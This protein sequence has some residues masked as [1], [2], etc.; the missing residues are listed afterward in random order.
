MAFKAPSIRSEAI[1]QRTLAGIRC[2]IHPDQH[3]VRGQARASRG[4]LHRFVVTMMIPL[5]KVV[6]LAGYWKGTS[7][8][9]SCIGYVRNIADTAPQPENRR[10]IDIEERKRGRLGV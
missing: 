4:I 6:L 8:C 9:H 5:T 2:R 10:S 3:S 1:S 7:V